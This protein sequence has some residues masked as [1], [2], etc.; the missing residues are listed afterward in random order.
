[1]NKKWNKFLLE[2]EVDNNID[3]PSL[4]IKDS[5]NMNVWLTE[6]NIK[7]GIGSRLIQIALDFME[8]LEA[9]SD[10]IQNIIL[11]GSLANYNWTEYS[12]IDLHILVDFTHVNENIDLVRDYF[13]TKKADW[14]KSHQIMIKNHE[15]EIYVQDIHEPHISTGVYSLLED[16]WITKPNKERP[17]ID[18]NCFSIK[19]KSLMDQINRLEDLY[20]KKNYEAVF[21]V[22]DLLKNKIKRLR[23]CGLMEKGIFSTENLVFKALRNK[24]FIGKLLDFRRDAYDKMMSINNAV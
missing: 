9:D 15:V 14:N 8:R 19:T 24:G 18:Y 21:N 12:D 5:L 4:E 10:I 20:N 22:G 16:Q 3:L 6:D 7:P 2:S 11:T 17:T 1:M 13:N 23:R